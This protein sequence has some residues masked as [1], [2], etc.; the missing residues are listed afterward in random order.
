[1]D[2]PYDLADLGARL[3]GE[4]LEV[5]EEALKKIVKHTFGWARE[6][7]QLSPNKMDDMIAP[8]LIPIE[9]YVMERADEVNPDD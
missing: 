1:M 6:S 5:A 8:F 7:A 2:K 9:A 3:K 4:G